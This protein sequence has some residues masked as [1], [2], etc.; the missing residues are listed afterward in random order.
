MKSKNLKS[1][2]N[3]YKIK[4][5]S[6]DRHSELNGF[7]NSY[8]KEILE[9]PIIGLEITDNCESH[10]SAQI[11]LKVID[12]STGFSWICNEFLSM[13]YSIKFYDFSLQ[14][15]EITYDRHCNIYTLTLKGGD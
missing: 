2:I 8:F 9:N 15:F 4:A 1:I 5:L 14:S 10:V 7:I 12:Q 6:L 13:L 3:L 11:K